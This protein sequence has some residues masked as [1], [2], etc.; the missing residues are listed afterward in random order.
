MTTKFDGKTVLF[1]QLSLF[2]SQ[3]ATFA[4]IHSIC[5][6][7]KGKNNPQ[8]VVVYKL[9]S[10][11]ALAAKTASKNSLTKAPLYYIYQK[12]NYT[13]RILKK[14]RENGTKLKKKIG[15]LRMTLSEY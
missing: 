3:I 10:H 14:I 5:K 6:H 12:V 2:R 9:S 8:Y 11:A 1:Y 4:K 15:P 13:I 7:S